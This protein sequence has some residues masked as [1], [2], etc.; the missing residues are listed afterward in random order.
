MPEI[1]TADV[2][3]PSPSSLTIHRDNPN[4]YALPKEAMVSNVQHAF[5]EAFCNLICRHFYRDFEGILQAFL[6]AFL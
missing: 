3:L 4:C 2:L 1:A 6:K 5:L